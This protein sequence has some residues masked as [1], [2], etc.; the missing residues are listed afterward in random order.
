M[1]KELRCPVCNAE[2]SVPY[3]ALQVKCE[4]CDSVFMCELSEPQLSA[5]EAKANAER[6]MHYMQKNAELNVLMK[7][8]ATNEEQ[9]ENL[10]DLL[11]SKKGIFEAKSFAKREPAVR[12]QLQKLFAESS[13]L[14]AQIDELGTS[15][16]RD[17]IPP[18]HRDPEILQE[19]Y[20]ALSSGRVSTIPQALD[21]SDKQKLSRRE[22]EL[23][24]KQLELQA[25]QIESTNRLAEAKANE[26][27]IRHEH[28]FDPFYAMDSVGNLLHGAAA[29]SKM[30]KKIK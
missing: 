1:L 30:I 23:A 15:F 8:L 29:V 24:Q 7:K 16:D 25:Q 26:T 5:V 9:M 21:L 10:R 19:M 2:L 27:V 11:N 18:D 13:Q 28:G 4:Y 20:Y 3:N 12:A 17:M 14:R 22:H 6:L